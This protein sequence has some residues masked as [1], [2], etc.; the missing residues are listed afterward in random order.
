MSIQIEALAARGGDALPFEVVERKS[1]GH[2]DTIADAVADGPARRSVTSLRLQA[3]N[4]A[5]DN[6]A[7]TRTEAAYRPSLMLSTPI[8][9]PTSLACTPQSVREKRVAAMPSRGHVDGGEDTRADCVSRW[10]C[11]SRSP[12]AAQ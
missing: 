1:A 10:T 5:C 3:L 8:T 2:P 11:E 9:R 7:K 6:P 12:A 4:A